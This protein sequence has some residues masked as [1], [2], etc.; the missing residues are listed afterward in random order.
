MKAIHL[1]QNRQEI[2]LMPKPKAPGSKEWT[3]GYWEITLE[4]AEELKEAEIFFHEKKAEPSFFGGIIKD[5]Q[6]ADKPEWL[7]HIIFTFLPDPSFRGK[8]AGRGGWTKDIKIV[9]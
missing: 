8:I 9:E 5:Y 4:Q 2:A 6:I 1:I 7:G 3:S